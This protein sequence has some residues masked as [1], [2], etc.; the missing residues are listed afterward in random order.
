MNITGKIF[1]INGPI[2]YVAGN[3][4]FKMNEMVYVGNEKLV[5]EVIG[6]TKDR[7][8]IQVFEETTGLKPGQEVYSTG[9]AISVTLAPGI[10]GNI[11]DGI[12]RPLKEISAKSGAF[13]SRGVS[14]ESLNTSKLWD[15]H[16]TVKP[17]DTIYG[18]TIIAEVPE[19]AAITHKSMVPPEVS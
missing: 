4:G 8:T 14:V 5:G 17:G 12:E 6:L 19:S 1:G 13:I 3:Q 18:G 10:I 9:A 11:F 2:V 15:V 7:T 16:I